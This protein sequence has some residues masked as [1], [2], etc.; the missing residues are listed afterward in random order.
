METRP[1]VMPAQS[2]AEFRRGRAVRLLAAFLL[3]PPC[4][5]VGG[6]G[7]P[8]PIPAARPRFVSGTEPL[9]V[10]GPNPDGPGVIVRDAEFRDYVA[11]ASALAAGVPA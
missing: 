6:R 4:N 5:V 3:W 10:L 7:R 1:M 9:V 8:G 2:D 11:P